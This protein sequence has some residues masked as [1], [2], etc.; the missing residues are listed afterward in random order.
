MGQRARARRPKQ[1]GL[2]RRKRESGEGSEKGKR[3]SENEIVVG[4]EG[5]VE[6]LERKGE[7][8]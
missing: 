2:K 1:R 4:S 6:S 5:E 8:R 7:K 3:E